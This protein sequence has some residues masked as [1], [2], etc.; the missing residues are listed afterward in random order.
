MAESCNKLT[1]KYSILCWAGCHD[2]GYNHVPIYQV[3]DRNEV[4]LEESRNT[5]TVPSMFVFRILAYLQR[6]RRSKLIIKFLSA[7]G[8]PLSILP[9][10]T[11]HQGQNEQA[12][13]ESD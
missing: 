7:S 2:C 8:R 9:T 3:V 5:V 4:M 6:R 10:F 13:E 1:A 12:D 11:V